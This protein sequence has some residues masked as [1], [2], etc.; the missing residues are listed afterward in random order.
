[1][2]ASSGPA[3]GRASGDESLRMKKSL[4]ECQLEG[5]SYQPFCS[6][7]IGS[8]R[9]TSLYSGFQDSSD[10]RKSPHAS[11]YLGYQEAKGSIYWMEG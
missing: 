9:T 8:E 6:P 5:S 10:E 11:W 1:M 7:N 2:E 3:I 4:N